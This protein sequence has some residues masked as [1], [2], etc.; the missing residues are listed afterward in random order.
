MSLISNFL[1]DLP[2]YLLSLH[3]ILFA[4]SVHES[5][6]G[7]AALRLG[8]PTARNFGRITLNPVKHIDPIGFIC[9]LIAHVGWAKPVP[10]NT[11]NFKKPKR[12][13]A[14]SGAAG[15]LSN[16]ILALI[17]FIILRIVMI[18]MD[19]HFF[20][21]VV[22]QDKLYIILKQQYEGSIEYTVACLFIFLLLLGVFCNLSLAIFNMLPFP[23]FDGSRIFYAFLPNKIYFGIM[24]YERI[25]MIV[26][27]IL[28]AFGFLSGPLAWLL[29]SIINGLFSITRMPASINLMHKYVYD[30]FSSLTA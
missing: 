3:V 14:I 23:P 30:L 26:L 27:L 21:E 9:M 11:R 2:I 15:P 25:I 20:E 28:F 29:N 4:F 1:S 13:M 19:N 24:K 17:N 5:A 16:L 22:F 8:D 10:I 6:H 7:Y 18:F 12:D